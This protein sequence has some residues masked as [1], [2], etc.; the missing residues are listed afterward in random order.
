M[1]VFV[2]WVVQASQRPAGVTRAGILVAHICMATGSFHTGKFEPSLEPTTVTQH[3]E[4]LAEGAQVLAQARSNCKVDTDQQA[5][6]N[7]PQ[8]ELPKGKVVSNQVVT[9]LF[10]SMSCL[11]KIDQPDSGVSAPE[12]YT[13]HV[14]PWSARRATISSQCKR[15]R[16]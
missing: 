14:L 16:L 12:K 2:A 10:S 4:A 3:C 8:Q 15:S 1:K 5:S 6:P 11:R 13:E 9:G 7:S